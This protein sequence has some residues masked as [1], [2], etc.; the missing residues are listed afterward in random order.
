MELYFD[1]TRESE[2]ASL[3][4]SMNLD[5][6]QYET[7]KEVIDTLMRDTLYSIILGLEGSASIGSI[8]EE[9]KIQ[10][11]NGNELNDGD[12]S[13]YAYEYFHQENR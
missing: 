12:L 7:M 6:K 8:Q 4:G 1:K 3:I 11:E 13:H 9:Y 2:V 5:D 10:D